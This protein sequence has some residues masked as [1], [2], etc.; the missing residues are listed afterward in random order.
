[1]RPVLRECVLAPVKLRRKVPTGLCEVH[2]IAHHLVPPGARLDLLIDSIGIELLQD[3]RPHV[4]LDFGQGRFR[5]Q[6]VLLVWV[7]LEIKELFVSQIPSLRMG[8]I[9]A[10]QPHDTTAWHVR[11]L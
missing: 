3:A 2:R 6:S 9:V 10:V 11:N 8:Y 7:S 1:M 4:L 5:G